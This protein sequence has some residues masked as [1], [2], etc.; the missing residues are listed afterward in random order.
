[1]IGKSL[2]NYEITGQLGKGGMGEVYRARDKR[3]DRD[4]A[5]KVLPPELT[6]DADRL[7]RF[8][9]E[10]K[11]L[12]SLNHPN[13]AAVYSFESVEGASFLVMELV[14]GED[15]S[16]RLKRGPIPVDEAL[17]FAA[18]IAEGLDAAHERGVIHRDLKPG[19]VMVDGEDRV[20]LLDFGLAK[21]M[22]AVGEPEGGAVDLSMSP[23]LTAP[24]TQAGVIMGTAA[25]MSPEQA[26]G[27]GVDKRSDIW[28]FG[29]LLFEMLTASSLFGGSTVSDSI[30]G[31]LR[32]EV[33]W[34]ELPVE[35]PASVQRLLRRCLEKDPKRRLRD[36]GDA[37][38]EL[39]SPDEPLEAT[40]IPVSVPSAPTW[41][42]AVP[43]LI[44]LVAVAALVTAWGAWS[45]SGPEPS[46]SFSARLNLNFPEEAPLAPYGA[47]P[48]G[49]G[50]P[51]LELTPDGTKLVYVALV[52][53]QTQLY[54]RDMLT[55][56]VEPI[57]YT[58]GASSLF[59]SP[60]GQSV[61]FFAHEQLMRTELDGGEPEALTDAVFAY[62]G[63][64]A[65]DGT[66]YFVGREGYG[67]FKIPS[68][69][70][71][72]EEVTERTND[73]QAWPHVLPGGEAML[74]STFS[75]S[76]LLVDLI[77]PSDPQVLLEDGIA[78]RYVDTG[79]LLF[80][81]D[82]RLL[83]VPFDLDG[84]RVTGEPVTL[85]E[86][87]RTDGLQRAEFSVSEDGMLVYVAGHD[88]R[89]GYL[90]WA[91]RQGG[92][93]RLDLPLQDYQSFAISPS[94]QRLAMPIVEDDGKDIWIY[95]FDR[96][97]APTRLTFG[98]N[99]WSIVWSPDERFLIHI[100]ADANLERNY[101]VATPVIGGNRESI[102]LIEG[103]PSA[104]TGSITPDGKEMIFSL[105]TGESYMNMRRSPIEFGPSSVS[106]GESEELLGSP[107]LEIFAAIS[108]DGQ[109][110][111]YTSDET[112]RWEIYVASYPTLEGRVRVSTDGGEEARW[113]PDGRELIYRWGSQWF[114]VDVTYEPEFHCGEPRLLFEGPYI[115]VL[116]YS[117]D[118]SA[119]GERFL[120]IEGPEQGTAATELVALTNFFDKL[121]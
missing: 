32:G 95:D 99:A 56:E 59:L 26:R 47:M 82:G 4:V 51:T 117:W 37:A 46:P 101:L 48:F 14:E 24:M 63:D 41:L 3:L 17:P 53:G 2:G 54:L 39:D 13:I 83:A 108:P 86:D 33:D 15:L 71:A 115:N 90:A 79:H 102:P 40:D 78:A 8:E 80:S 58:E 20:K 35:T 60:D 110:L 31:I 44:A 100:S 69:G 38:L 45:G 106:V 119:D 118:M 61:G 18:Q 116:G 112:E 5:I 12:A 77:T 91:D 107:N 21:A 28:A 25:Y 1:M 89:A 27:Q 75:G 103:T 76:V 97:D 6:S 49:V 113:T 62:G 64:W 19:N 92:S 72:V 81:R 30:A 105:S 67:A 68:L 120:V 114:V 74:V 111:A 88:A 50:Q 23:T 104:I 94:G 93:E 52:D 96:L 121:P 16:E 11:V 7:A 109:W 10:A 9:R 85:L 66:I 65:P 84:Y 36:I 73:A 87:I 98:L 70:G 34:S 43:W 55:G 42:R 57:P 29:C 22:D